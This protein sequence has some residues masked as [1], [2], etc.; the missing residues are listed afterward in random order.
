M[1]LVKRNQEE[2]FVESYEIKNFKADLENFNILV[3]MT[4]YSLSEKGLPTSEKIVHKITDFKE[5]S[6]EDTQQIVKI[7]KRSGDGSILMDDG[8]NP[9]TEEATVSV[10][11]QVNKDIKAFS[12]IVTFQT[13]G[14]SLYEEIKNAIYS[15]FR[16]YYLKDESF[17]IE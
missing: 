7:N 17:I 12:E 1:P 13:S 4:K 14:L 15:S 6:V 3:E 9:I 8:G 11:K 2:Q 16:K 10:K 5:L